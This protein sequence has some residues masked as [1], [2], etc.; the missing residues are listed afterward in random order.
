METLAV[1][2]PDRTFDELFTP[3]CLRELTRLGGGAPIRSDSL[4]GL[5]AHPQVAEAAVIGVTHPKWGEAPL[6]CVVKVAG[7]EPTES[8]ILTFLDGKVAKWQLP[9]GFVWIDE[10]PKTSVGKFS[11]K[12]LRDAHADVLMNDQ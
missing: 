6:A 2:M 1:L 7:E 5:K 11:K 3:A 4:D 9:K 12:T 8:E 10:V